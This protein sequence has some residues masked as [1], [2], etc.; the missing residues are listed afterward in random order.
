MLRMPVLVRQI[1]LKLF[2]D[3]ILCVC[4]TLRSFPWAFKLLILPDDHCVLEKGG[5]LVIFFVMLFLFAFAQSFRV[6]TDWWLSYWLREGDGQDNVE[7]GTIH[8]HPDRDRF[9]AILAAGV[10]GFFLAQVYF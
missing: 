3:V 5:G 2:G 6:F 8:D 1:T 4:F 10:A 7:K 9:V